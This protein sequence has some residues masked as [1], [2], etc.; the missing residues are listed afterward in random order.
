MNNKEFVKM[1]KKIN[2]D[3]AVSEFTNYKW[4][5][6]PP[7]QKGKKQILHGLCRSCMAGE[8]KTLVHLEDGVVVKVE[9][10][11]EAPP[12]FGVMCGKGISEIM[13]HY[14]PYR[15]KNPLVRT[16]PEKGLN[17]DPKWREVSWE[18][19]LNL[20]ADKLRK[21]RAKD[22]KSMVIC[23]GF[24]Q[25]DTILREPFAAA[26]GTPNVLYAHGPLCADH[27]ATCLVHAGFPVAVTDF[28]YCNYTVNLGRSVGP[29]QASATGIRRFAKA[30]RRG[31]KLVMIDP[32][33]A[34]DA[35][36]GEWVPIIP[37]TDLAFLLAMAHVIIHEN[38]KFDVNFVKNRTNAP[39]FIGA[40]GYY[41]R[42]PATGKPMMWDSADKK[43]KTFDSEFKDIALTGSYEVNGVKVRPAFDLIKEEFAKY[44]PEWA[45]KISTVPAATIRRIANEFV[46]H[47]E[48][49]RTIEIDGFTFPLRPSCLNSERQA[50]SHRG[51]TV[52]DLTGKMINMLVGNVEVPGGLLSNGYRG[53]I[54]IPDKDGVVTPKYEAIPR[55]FNYPPKRLD[56]AE[57]YPNGHAGVYNACLAILNPG[58]YPHDYKAEVL[59]N[60]GGNPIRKNAQPQT[61]VEAF[62]KI[63]FIVDIAYHFDEPSYLADVV[64]PDHASFE[65]L[66][67]L[68]LHPQEKS[69]SDETNGIQMIQLRDPVPALFNTWDSDDIYTALAEKLGIL[70]GKGGVYDIVNNFVDPRVY[71]NGM[72]VNEGY[73]LDISKKHTVEEIY[74]QAFRGWK[75]NTEKWTLQDLKKKGFMAKWDPPREHYNYYFFPDNK[76]RHPFYFTHLKKTGEELKANMAKVNFAFPGDDMEA[77]F[78]EFSAIPHWIENAEF[79]APEEYDLWVVNWMTP[80]STHDSSGNAAGNPW[81]AEVYT[82]DPYE[83]VI[84]INTDTAAA[85]NL[86]D[87]DTVVIESR[88]GKTE[89]LIKT[90]ELMHPQVVGISG[91]YGLGTPQSNPLM[92][93][94]PHYNSLLALDH[95]SVDAIS[96]GQ[97]ASPRVKITKKEGK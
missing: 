90:T 85:K 59:I 64:L 95:K 94:G 60:H 68:Y 96:G 41:F 33:S 2:S 12:N 69:L 48:I 75:Y 8:C 29:N 56:L 83:G 66:R 5:D 61:Y 17:I 71:E 31:M 20:V 81:L 44:T 37:G 58:K 74:D 15:I 54:L 80:Y 84:C 32:R 36:K 21:A 78:D 45:E 40:D 86:K 51:G 18:E 23:E 62:K 52:A 49:G 46:Q 91:S 27:Y 9:G 34:F 26:F 82:Q 79:K 76:T 10:N 93:R 43:A 11:P 13:N 70:Y 28:E 92:K 65:R 97:E 89:G 42:D 1:M 88:Y 16:N 25:R 55:K 6:A 53:P 22:P 77:F 57:Y 4:K 35:S 30:L 14:N 38:L 19:A 7:E 24:G 72:N 39:Y 50:V 63:P 3:K 67:V 73:K 87:G 47:A